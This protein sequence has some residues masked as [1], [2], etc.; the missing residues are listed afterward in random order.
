MKIAGE[1]DN[2]DSFQRKSSFLHNIH[3][4]DIL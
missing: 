3:S 4:E 1:T 2:M